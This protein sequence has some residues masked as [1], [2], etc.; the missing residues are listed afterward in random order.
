M[1]K[2]G[3]WGSNLEAC[4]YNAMSLSLREQNY[5]LRGAI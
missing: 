3:V 1:N 2:Y 5:N 4:I